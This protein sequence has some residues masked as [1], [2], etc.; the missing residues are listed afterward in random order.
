MPPN[1]Y[2]IL[3]HNVAAL[4]HVLCIHTVANRSDYVCCT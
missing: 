3:L 2:T 4:Y 1:I